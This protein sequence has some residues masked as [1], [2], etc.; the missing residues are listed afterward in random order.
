MQRVFFVFDGFFDGIKT[1]GQ[2]G[3]L[4]R[5]A[6]HIRYTAGAGAGFSSD[7]L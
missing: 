7:G 2:D 5:L 3:T 1:A 4:S 6:V